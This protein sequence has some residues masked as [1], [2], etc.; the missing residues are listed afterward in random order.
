MTVRALYI[1]IP[2]CERKC[3][4][5]DFVSLPGR[6]A[7]AAYIDALCAE[8]ELL[9]QRTGDLELD[10]VFIGGGTPSFVEPA[11]IA[12]VL[13]TVR[14]RFTLT[15]TCEVTIEANP[16]STTTARAAAWRAA[17]CNRVSLGIQ[18]THPD[19]LG[20]LGRVHDRDRALDAID[21]V[22]EAGFVR[23]NCDLIYAVPGL[24]DERWAQ[25]VGEVTG[26]GPDHVSAYELTVEA[27]TPLHRAVR[28]G[29]VRPADAETALRQ[30]AIAVEAL[31]ARGYAQYEV[32]NFARPGSECRH[33]LMY[34]SRG[35]Y[36]AAGLGAHGHLPPEMAQALGL[37]ADPGAVSVRY[38]HGRQIRDYITRATAG[39]LPLQE[40][41]SVGAVGAERERLL[42]GLR[43]TEGIAVAES[44]ELEAMAA[45][46][47]MRRRDGRVAVT[48]TGEAVLDEI[49]RRLVPDDVTEDAPRPAVAA[50]STG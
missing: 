1:H 40:W 9:G 8:L 11:A 3:E 42:L 32:S 24:D 23:V 26:R 13:G 38:W 10:T 18:S 21:E 17:G 45:A 31:A 19:I 47:L 7:E 6:D 16:S 44:T 50:T 29:T 34:W 4:Y 20:F 46:G 35:H 5:C 37:A 2:F 49:I 14:G 25:T 22:H 28:R 48:A 30:H 39:E 15:A 36:L 43:L 12:R 27:G 33:N 41:E